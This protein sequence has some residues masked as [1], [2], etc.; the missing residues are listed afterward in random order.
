MDKKEKEKEKNASASEPEV[1]YP[2]VCPAC[3]STN[4]VM[5]EVHGTIYCADCGYVLEQ[6]IVFTGPEWRSFEYEQAM[7]RSRTGSP[8]RYSSHDYGF[9]IEISSKD[10]EGVPIMPSEFARM[11]KW[12]R[13]IN[14][15]GAL[16]RN[17]KAGLNEI[18]RLCTNLRL[19]SDVREL[20][21]KIYRDAT[22]N[23][24]IRGRSISVVAGATVYAACRLLR[25]LRTL[26]EISKAAGASK[27][28]ISRTYKF[29]AR[30]LPKLRAGPP[31]PEEYVDRFCDK[32]GLGQE[33]VEKAKEILRKAREA[34]LTSGRGPQG[35]AAAAIYIAAI[36]TGNR[37]TQKEVAQ[38]ANVTEVTIRNRYKELTEK[39]GLDISM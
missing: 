25:H 12:T 6:D 22:K 20:A 9:G 17:L 29:L 11:K 36:L 19:P 31:A 30:H 8:I 33:T 5:D 37:K 7:E 4:L 2:E 23:N 18:E 35:M 28:D 3:G 39:L 14:T 15:S 34:G 38:V 24:L 27:K 26:Q 13:R 16:E 32:L 10:S 21:S 1:S